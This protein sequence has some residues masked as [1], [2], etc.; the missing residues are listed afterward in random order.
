MAAE[1]LGVSIKTLHRWGDKG[2]IDVIRTPGGHR[3]FDT[4]SV[5][6]ERNTQI[7]AAK[8]PLVNILA[9]AYPVIDTGVYGLPHFSQSLNHTKAGG[10][11]KLRNL[12]FS[13]PGKKARRKI[14]NGILNLKWTITPPPGFTSEET[15]GTIALIKNSIAKPN[16]E[17]HS[18]YRLFISSIILDIF[19]AGYA[20]IERQSA[21][22]SDRLFWMW[23]INPEFL[24]ENNDWNYEERNRLYRYYDTQGSVNCNDWVGFFYDEVFIIQ[25]EACSWQRITPSVLSIACDLIEDWL[26]VGAYQGKVTSNS[27]RR[28]IITFE[29]CNKVE[30]DAFRAFWENEVVNSGKVPIF[31][32]KVNKVSL[33]AQSNEDLYLQYCEYLL[34]II[35]V[36]FDVSHRDFN[37]TDHD[38]RATANVAADSTFQDAILPYA[39]LIQEVINTEILDHFETTKGFKFEYLDTE[40]RNENEESKRIKEL[41]KEGI[42]TLNEARKELGKKEVKNGNKLFNGELVEEIE[43]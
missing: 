31:R 14:V 21:A 23:I 37:I 27:N 35:A 40:P 9:P 24:R 11:N 10:L 30:L 38:N 41:Y 15:A 43:E 1:K 19:T 39:K 4:A 34:K 18:K 6:T 20:A 22:E 13:I 7:S 16:L 33:A 42:Y 26:E 28:D 5:K 8:N 2:L 3:R 12:A 29:D 25:E 32:G 36:A 17:D